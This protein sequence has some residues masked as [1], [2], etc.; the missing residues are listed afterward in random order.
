MSSA[1]L[2]DRGR[3]VLPKEVL[4]ELG[5]SRGDAVVFE[6]RGED[7]VVVKTSSKTKRLEEI[8]DWNPKRTGKVE[9]VS[10]KMMKEIW[11]T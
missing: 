8:M 2:D 9:K 7:F 5:A 11:K 1:I 6:K 3:V 4:E 10:P